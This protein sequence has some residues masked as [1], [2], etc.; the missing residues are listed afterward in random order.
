MKDIQNHADFR[1]I[2]IQRVGLQDVNLPFIIKMQDGESQTVLANIK[3]TVDLNENYKG[4]HMSRFMDI[5]TKWSKKNISGPQIHDILNELTTR[6][7]SRD[8]YIKIGF[9]YFLERPAPIS[10]QIGLLDYDCAFMGE[11][12]DGNYVFTMSVTVPF[13]SLCPCSKEIS[14]Y[15]AHNQRSKLSIKIRCLPHTYLWLEELI[16]LAESV[17]SSPVYPLLKREDEKYVTEYAYENPK[18]VEDTIRDIVLKLRAQANIIWFD[19]TCINF[20]SIHNHNA[21]ARHSEHIAR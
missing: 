9:K 18:F 21:Y 19:T 3:A 11:L 7:D 6:L 8:A 16:A 1:G 2:S 5:L 4:T 14:A 13:T 15:G 10:K 20:E 17:V 12:L